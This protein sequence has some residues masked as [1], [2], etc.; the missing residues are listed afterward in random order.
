MRNDR[1]DQIIKLKDS[2]VLGYAE[3]GNPDA[4]CLC[5]PTQFDKEPKTC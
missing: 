4:Q 5:V 3:Y 1:T 2:R